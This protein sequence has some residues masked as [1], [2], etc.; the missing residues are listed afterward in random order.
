MR[1]DVD[2]IDGCYYHIFNKSIEG[3]KIFLGQNEYLRMFNTFRYYQMEDT[4]MPLSQFLALKEVHGQG[5]D[6]LLLA[7]NTAKDLVH[8]VAYCIMPTHIHFILKQLRKNGVSEFMRLV[9]NS[10]ARYF[11]VKH[12]RKGPLWQNRFKNVLV[13]SDEQLYHFTRYVHLNPV[14]ANLVSKP[15]QWMFSSYL[16]YMN[17]GSKNQKVCYFEDILDIRPSEYK[18][19]VEDQVNY[20]KELALIKHLM[21]E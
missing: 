13:G 5:F 14:T 19:F 12:K 8:I 17:R 18:R 7:R 20:Q 9:L 16:E 15:E 1:R 10:Y 4:P 6:E 2:L 3:F 21:L 11:N